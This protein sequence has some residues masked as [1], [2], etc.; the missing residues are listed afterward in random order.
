[1]E[2]KKQLLVSFLEKNGYKY[3]ESFGITKLNTFFKHGSRIL[4]KSKGELFAFKIKGLEGAFS[5]KN[6]ETALFG[7][8]FCDKVKESLLCD[9]FFTSDELPRYGIPISSVKVIYKKLKKKS[10]ELIIFLAYE[11]SKS[12]EIKNYID[13]LI[14]KIL[15]KMYLI[16]NSRRS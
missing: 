4:Q 8:K 3:A 6:E 14:L 9:G 11:E 12:I 5:K 16:C 10:G 7:R 15:G 1:M 13:E 2:F